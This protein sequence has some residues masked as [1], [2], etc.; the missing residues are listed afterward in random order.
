MFSVRRLHT[1]GSGVS[2]IAIAVKKP[3]TSIM[4]WT[5]KVIVLTICL[6]S[7]LRGESSEDVSVKV[8][9]GRPVEIASA[10]IRREK[11][12]LLVYGLVKKRLGYESPTSDCLRVKLISQNGT[13]LKEVTT[14]YS[15]HPFLYSRGS[16]YARSSFSCHLE[17]NPP[18]HSTVIIAYEQGS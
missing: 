3:W 12:E 13:I 9:S 15:P 2:N 6:T 18:P 7:V 11:D 1:I 16:G 8:I 17:V 10:N 4:H 14:R 5:G